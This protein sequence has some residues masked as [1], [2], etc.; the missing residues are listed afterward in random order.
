MSSF[1]GNAITKGKYQKHNA[2][3]HAL[4]K[5][6]NSTRYARS[7]SRARASRSILAFCA[8]SLRSILALRARPSRSELETCALASVSGCARRIMVGKILSSIVVRIPLRIFQLYLALCYHYCHN[9]NLAKY[10]CHLHSG[11]AEA[12]CISIAWPWFYLST[13]QISALLSVLGSELLARSVTDIYWHKHLVSN[14]L[15]QLSLRQ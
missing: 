1:Y 7:I 14:I 9:D 12:S 10:C 11:L 2:K 8:R 5:T 6:R 3:T 15:A 4:C 13:Y